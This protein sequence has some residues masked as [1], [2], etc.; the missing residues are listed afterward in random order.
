VFSS[1]SSPTIAGGASSCAVLVA[2]KGLA[3]SFCD[4]GPLMDVELFVLMMCLYSLFYHDPI[5]T[6]CIMASR[7]LDFV[8]RKSEPF[9]FWPGCLAS[10]SCPTAV[11][12][13]DRDFN[14]SL[15]QS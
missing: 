12:H 2:S 7:F 4:D 10:E 11:S 13:R 5:T 3:I 15:S 9:G 6:S 1:V 8:I 14:K